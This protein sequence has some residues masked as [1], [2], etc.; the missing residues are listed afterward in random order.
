MDAEDRR[1]LRKAINGIGGGHVSGLFRLSFRRS[2]EELYGRAHLP[3]DRNDLDTFISERNAV[4]HGYWDS[5][6]EGAT[7]AHR[8]AEYGT[9][10]LEKLIPRFF[11]YDG[12][13][14]DRTTSGIVPF[15]HRDPD[16]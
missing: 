4:V 12:P 11:R 3:V 1:K 15:K 14:Y 8:L 9:N 7:R 10:L 5:N 6:P 13:Y 16:W 2:L